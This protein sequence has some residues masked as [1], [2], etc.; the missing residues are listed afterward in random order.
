MKGILIFYLIFTILFV[1]LSVNGFAQ[2]GESLETSDNGASEPLYSEV[3]DSTELLSTIGG[4][5]SQV[6]LTLM[7]QHL[8]WNYDV[9]QYSATNS[10]TSINQDSVYDGL[11]MG[12]K[13]LTLSPYGL[14]I[15]GSLFIPLG[16]SESFY[17]T[18]SSSDNQGDYGATLTGLYQKNAQV[19]P[20]PYAVALNFAIG[21]NFRINEGNFNA[22]F[23]AGLATL[24][25]VENYLQT[26][27]NS[28]LIGLFGDV[29]IHFPFSPRWGMGVSVRGSYYPFE[30]FKIGDT[31][32]VENRKYYIETK[33]ATDIALG[34]EFVW[35]F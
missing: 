1:G 32:D 11:A 28:N 15:Y 7:Y 3:S 35:Y 2:S 23:A 17:Q 24:S 21:P 12:L 9:A 27:R 5:A 25:I 20:I 14:Y 22:N 30:F 16:I 8:V 10:R 33:S 4:S 29:D 34:V 26:I 19:F 13:Y 6:M 18:N 31:A